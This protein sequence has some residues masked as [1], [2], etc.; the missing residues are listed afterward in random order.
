[1]KNLLTAVLFSTFAYNAFAFDLDGFKDLKFGMPANEL[2]AKGYACKTAYSM[3]SCEG[4]DTLFGNLA[5][6][7]VM[8]KG[9]ISNVR[10]SVEVTP[11]DA[12]GL[13]KQFF[14]NFN[15][16][17][18]TPTSYVFMGATGKQVRKTFWKSVSGTSIAMNQMVNPEPMGVVRNGG[19]P[20]DINPRV[21]VHYLNAE[22]T[23]VNV[24]A[25]ENAVPTG[26][27]QNARSNSKDF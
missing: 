22:E 19:F 16:Q 5:A 12:E 27:A 15:S 24:K 2:A 11:K 17:L 3:L 10:V 8:F 9:G 20:I 18:G 1:M 7:E 13:E 21:T 6:V 25:A 26:N 14:Q 4:K 23:L